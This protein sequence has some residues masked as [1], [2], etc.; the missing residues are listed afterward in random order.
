MELQAWAPPSSSKKGQPPALA[1]PWEPLV[2]EQLAQRVPLLRHLPIQAADLAAQLAS[3]Q[4]S[5]A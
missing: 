1:L 4:I 3:L 2:L 5:L